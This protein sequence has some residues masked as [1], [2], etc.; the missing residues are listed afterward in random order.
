M[1]ELATP[2]AGELSSW[3]DDQIR[4]GLKQWRELTVQSLHA[5]SLLF[6]EAKRRGIDVTHEE[7]GIGWVFPAVGSGNLAPD[8]AVKMLGRQRQLR[9]LVGL[10]FE[11]QRQLANGKPIPVVMRDDPRVTIDL[12]LSKIGPSV[13][14]SVIQNGEIVPPEVQRVNI[15]AKDR[16]AK[17]A[18]PVRTYR[19]QTGP[20][21]TIRVGHTHFTLGEMY[22][23]LNREAGPDRLPP[24]PKDDPGNYCH[25]ATARLWPEEKE[26]LAAYCETTGMPEW[27]VVRRALRIMG[28][29]STRPKGDQS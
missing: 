7:K 29:I 12:P 27:E 10:P 1:S 8:V 16:T 6:M 21:G 2:T 15:R 22:E 13:L 25:T 4:A 24:G 9:A 17:A 19:L 5:Y 23:F 14:P 20:E 11:E 26:A 3:T 28:I 18:P